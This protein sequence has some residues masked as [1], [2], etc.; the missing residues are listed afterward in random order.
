MKKLNISM[1]D[2]THQALKIQAAKENRAMGDI[3]VSLITEYL[4]AKKESKS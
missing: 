4:E 3:I 1:P 2:E